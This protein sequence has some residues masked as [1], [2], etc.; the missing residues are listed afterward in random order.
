LKFGFDI[1][2]A[3]IMALLFIHLVLSVSAT[4][5]SIFVDS[6]DRYKDNSYR[7]SMFGF[8]FVTDTQTATSTASVVDLKW[9]NTG[10]Y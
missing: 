5:L 1:A 7:L 8:D 9:V 4:Q 6:Y 10:T 2:R 3:L